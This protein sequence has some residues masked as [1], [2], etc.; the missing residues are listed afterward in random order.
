MENKERQMAKTDKGMKLGD[1]VRDTLTGFTGVIVIRSEYLNGCYR[2]GVQPSKLDKDGKVPES[3]YFDVEQLELVKAKAHAPS[4]RSG[5]PC[6]A[7]K[8]APNPRR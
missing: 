5:G 3:I 2:M 1:I 7:P 4:S 8:R 6:D